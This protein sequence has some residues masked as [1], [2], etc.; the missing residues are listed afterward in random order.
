MSCHGWGACSPEGYSACRLLRR[1][2]KLNACNMSGGSFV[3]FVTAINSQSIHAYAGGRVASPPYDA[4]PGLLTSPMQPLT[5]WA[6]H[7]IMLCLA[8]VMDSVGVPSA[9][10]HSGCL[11]RPTRWARR[12][13][14]RVDSGRHATCPYA[15][16][17][18]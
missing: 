7:G 4:K 17:W 16:R 8:L 10:L 2:P 11:V 3:R 6:P 15:R 1:H 14:G 18:P 12:Q 5:A 13:H 9:W